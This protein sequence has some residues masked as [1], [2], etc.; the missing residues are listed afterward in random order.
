MSMS[1]RQVATMSLVCLAAAGG[2]GCHRKPAAT[3]V[4][5]EEARRLLLDR[6]WI[7]RLPET[8]RDR[9]QVFRF[10]PSMGGGV[11]QDRTLYAGQFELFNFEHDGET[12]RFHLHHT[13]EDRSASYAIERLP[14]GDENPFDLHLHI[15]DSPRGPQDYYS[16]RGMQGAAAEKELEAGLQKVWSSSSH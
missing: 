6:N 7:D 12:I 10:V 1:L 4:P 11:Y 16:I 14:G 9:L 8:A 2:T 5:A 13:G 15:K 3:A